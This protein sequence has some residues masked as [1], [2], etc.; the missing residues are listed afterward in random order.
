MCVKLSVERTRRVEPAM[1]TGLVIWTLKEALRV[2]GQHSSNSGTGPQA[3]RQA[4][5]VSGAP[6]MAVRRWQPANGP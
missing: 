1:C 3:G 2:V 4:G 6:A 5:S